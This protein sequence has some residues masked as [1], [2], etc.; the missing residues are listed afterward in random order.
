MLIGHGLRKKSDLWVMK[1]CGW[2][3]LVTLPL[4]FE[5]ETKRI[6]P[7]FVEWPNGKIVIIDND[8]LLVYY[9]KENLCWAAKYSMSF[10]QGCVYIE[11]LVSP[12]PHKNITS[13]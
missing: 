5:I 9:A 8:D 12:Y 11:S 2:S 1:D 3:K 6:G 7:L 10:T 13:T 4:V